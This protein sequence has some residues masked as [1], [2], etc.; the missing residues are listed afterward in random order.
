MNI[1]IAIL[2]ACASTLALTQ[3]DVARANY[4]AASESKAIVKTAG[5][6]LE[7][8][9]VFAQNASI[10]TTR[11]NIKRSGR[12]ETNDALMGVST[13]R[14]RVTSVRGKTKGTPIR[15]ESDIIIGKQVRPGTTNPA[16]FDRWGKS[17]TESIDTGVGPGAGPQR[18]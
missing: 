15:Y 10:S 1:R 7:P 2:A 11:S 16:I 9:I 5:V 6:G 17:K 8:T 4:D 18:R 13:T 12:A 14:G 3:A